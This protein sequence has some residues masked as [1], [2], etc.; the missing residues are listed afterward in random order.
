MSET[1]NDGESGWGGVAFDTTGTTL[2]AARGH[3]RMIT[4]YDVEV[5]IALAN[6][7]YK[8]FRIISI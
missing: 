4:A 1:F 6:A 3:Q 2:V 5:S 8:H 7:F